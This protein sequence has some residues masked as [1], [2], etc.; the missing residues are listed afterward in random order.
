MV[1]QNG[2]S[3]AR[4]SHLKPQC[5]LRH[6]SISSSSARVPGLVALLNTFKASHSA[7]DAGSY[8]FV[9]ARTYASRPGRPKQH[10]GRVTST[11]KTKAAPTK[12]ASASRSKTA[13]RSKSKPKTAK[14]KKAKA[15]PKAKPKPKKK[16]LTTKQ[17]EAKALKDTRTKIAELKET[18][19]KPPPLTRASA[20]QALHGERTRAT[21]GESGGINTTIATIRK[22]A[23]EYRAFSPEQLEASYTKLARSSIRLIF[24][25]IITT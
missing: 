4:L 15:K 7:I 9:P 5:L 22:A 20:W 2:R 1:F 8:A 17:K 13:S 11:R 18:A 6:S 21:K 19:L 14:A 16:A 10:T 3:I 12:T 24:F 25:S 23:E